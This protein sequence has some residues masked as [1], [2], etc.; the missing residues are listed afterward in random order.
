MLRAG[1]GDK[2][3][4]IVRVDAAIVDELTKPAREDVCSI[5]ESPVLRVDLH[6]FIAVF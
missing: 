3:I 1:K 6:Y 4:H 2:I 5:A